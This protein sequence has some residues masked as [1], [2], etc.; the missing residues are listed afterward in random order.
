[1]KIQ[2]GR[3]K[4]GGLSASGGSLDWLRELR[5]RDLAA[6]DPGR[7]YREI[8][9]TGLLVRQRYGGHADEPRTEEAFSDYRP[10][11]GLQV[12]HRA[13]FTRDMSPPFERIVAEHL[14]RAHHA[15]AVLADNGYN[16]AWLRGLF[17][18][19]GGRLWHAARRRRRARSQAEAR[20]RRW[21]RSKRALIETVFSMLADQFTV[22]TTRARSLLG[23]KV[24]VA[25]KLLAFNVSIVLNQILGR[26]ALAMKSL[27]M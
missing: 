8:P 24:R 14:L 3:R 27:Y 23:V 5:H 18:R 12:A 10:V 20:L 22:E 7:S 19:Q 13:T 17:G 25:A 21:H 11:E 6:P 4:C 15:W 9:A 2:S 26:P 1:M 16:G